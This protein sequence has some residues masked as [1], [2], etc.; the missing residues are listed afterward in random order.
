[1]SE[2]VAKRN[3]S[4]KETLELI[5][6]WSDDVV[7]EELEG[8]RNKDVYQRR[9]A[10][11]HEKGFERNI[12]QCREKVKKLKKTVVDNNTVTGRKRKTCKFYEE[13]DRIL[14]VKPA[15]KS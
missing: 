11:L 10:K 12:S 5:P 3:W 2:K 4:D 9:C 8:R 13:L 1:M 7:Q 15:K 6:L 14:G